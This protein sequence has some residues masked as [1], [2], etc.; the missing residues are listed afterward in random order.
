MRQCN[1]RWHTGWKTSW[2][3]YTNFRRPLFNLLPLLHSTWE[4]PPTLLLLQQTRENPVN[5]SEIRNQIQ[6]CIQI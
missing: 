5:P 2:H 6:K 3:R 1:R 4:Q